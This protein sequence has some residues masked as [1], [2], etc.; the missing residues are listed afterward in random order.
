MGADRVLIEIITAANMAGVEQAKAGLLGF[1]P[2][3]MVG[4]AAI[5][6]LV[7][8]G[9]SAIEVSREHE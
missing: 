9:K 4:A 8:V 1:S 6:A 3:A 2:V 7:V 5:G